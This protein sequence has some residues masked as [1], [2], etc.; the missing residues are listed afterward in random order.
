MPVMGSCC[1]TCPFKPDEKGIWQDTKLANEVI[2]RNLLKS[3][4]ICHHPKLH[5]KEETHRCKGFFDYAF[6]IYERLGFDPE[7]NLIN[8]PK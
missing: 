6:E 1:K 8:N 2:R 4:Q 3:Q 7:N 5:G